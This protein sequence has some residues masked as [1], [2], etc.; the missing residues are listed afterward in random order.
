MELTKEDFEKTM[1]TV[2]WGTLIIF[3]GVCGAYPVPVNFVYENNKIYFHGKPKGKKYQYLQNVKMVQ[4][5]VVD[6]YSLI[7]SYFQTDD[8]VTDPQRKL[9]CMA[10]QC[11]ISIKVT[12]S[13]KQLTDK[14]EKAAAMNILMNK[15]QP[16]GKYEPMPITED[17]EYI[18]KVPVFELT[19]LYKSYRTK[20]CDGY[21]DDQKTDIKH[22]LEQRGTPND[23]RTIKM[24]NKYGY[25]PKNKEIMK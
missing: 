8:K 3:D 18:D 19:I 21:T 24:I 4:F 13:V 16:E 5:L 17:T 1:N 11:F 15:L 22:N 6:D 20:F 10:S 2:P 23:K 7:P 25:K 12:A 14:K 9:P